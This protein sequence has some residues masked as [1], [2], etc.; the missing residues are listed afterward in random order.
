M[1]DLSE[2]AKQ[3]C[4][5]NLKDNCHRCP[6]RLQCVRNLGAGR[7][8]YERWLSEVNTAAEILVNKGV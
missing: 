5:E 8:A 7:E 1:T 3:I 4:R 6:L 2:A